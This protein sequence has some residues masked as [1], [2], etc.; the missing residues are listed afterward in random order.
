MNEKILNLLCGNNELLK[1]SNINL[2]Q[3]MLVFDN[4]LFLLNIKK[5]FD[6]LDIEDDDLPF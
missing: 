1:S 2:R 5:F 4:C 3:K 6:D